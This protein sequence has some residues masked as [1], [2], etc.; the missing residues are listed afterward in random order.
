VV[1]V[2]TTVTVE[3]E[4][5]LAVALGPASDKVVATVE[6]VLGFCNTAIPS[7]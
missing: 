7:P 5:E 3:S 4:D 6:D 2:T 1:D